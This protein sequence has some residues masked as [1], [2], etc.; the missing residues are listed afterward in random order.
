MSNTEE[1]L[2]EAPQDEAWCEEIARTLDAQRERARQMLAERRARFG[3]LHSELSIRMAELADELGRHESA[4]LD[5]S[6]S[7]DSREVAL[8]QQADQL[9]IQQAELRQHQDQWE[10]FRR[11]SQERHQ[12]LLDEL[13]KRLTQFD[14]QQADLAAREERLH[15]QLEE[16][17][18]RQGELERNSANF[19]ERQQQLDR[20]EEELAEQRARF[21]EIQRNH[22][23]EAEQLTRN[24]AELNQIQVHFDQQRQALAER[25]R[26]I[27]RQRRNVARQLR[28]RK[29]E[30]V[31][32]KELLHAEVRSSTASQQVQLQQRLSELQGK[33]ERA[34]EDSTNREQQR[35]ELTQRVTSLQARLEQRESEA[36][37][38]AAVETQLRETEKQRDELL[39]NHDQAGASSGAQ[40]AQLN[41][42]IKSLT[43]RC[44]QQAEQLAQAQASFDKQRKQ[45]E[46]DLA[47]AG[48]ATGGAD[49]AAELAQ[50]RQEKAQLE[51]WL[52]EAESKAGSGLDP[53]AAQELADLKRRLEMASQDCRDLR[54]KNTE[55]QRQVDA[56]RASAGV[57]AA[58]D[59]GMD[60]ESQ[61][62]RML[63]QLEA[64]FDQDNEEQKQQK[65]SIEEAIQKTEQAI[66]AKQQEVAAKDRE[67]DDLRKLLENQASSIGD[68][69]VGAAAIAGV[70]DQD[71]LIRQERE[72]LKKLQDS[73]R[74]QL[75]QAEIEL[76]MERAKIA[77]ER[78]VMEEKL[79]SFEIE[80]SKLAVSAEPQAADAAGGKK[81]SRGRW[82]TRLGLRDDKG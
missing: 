15:Q 47:K 48:E 78:S 24:M 49:A 59:G 56:A 68:V 51:Q 9:A 17:R 20:K 1:T 19:A 11:Q 7:V 76:S 54:N 57:S 73:L 65:L 55:L 58:A 21:E 80:K 30:L 29:K 77:R 46:Q 4:S 38:L 25:E 2:R 52:R 64:D 63:A 5:R 28:A 67:I 33:Y 72:S 70:L 71:E 6:V 27:A 22:K 37:R 44:A 66:A 69:A 34:C 10:Q 18:T 35:D 53:A 8:K 62:R 14:T 23:N 41:E 26:E 39:K 32:E 81:G 45:W 43:E 74:E 50:L 36:A 42:K 61:K 82:L 13:Q 40:I 16:L 60:W 79:Q 12:H 75:R 3:V 31:T